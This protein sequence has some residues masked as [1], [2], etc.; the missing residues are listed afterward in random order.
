MQPRAKDFRFAARTSLS[1]YWGTAL[2][3]SFVGVLLGGTS[4]SFS[5]SGI[6]EV[7]NGHL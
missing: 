6:F 5:T 4:A 2:L 3:T 1:G 7:I